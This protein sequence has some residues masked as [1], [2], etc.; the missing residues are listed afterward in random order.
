MLASTLDNLIMA[1]QTDVAE[2][3]RVGGVHSTTIGRYLA[4]ENEPKLSILR[5][6]VRALKSPVARA[7]IANMICEGSDC[8]V[9]AGPGAGSMD[10]NGDGKVDML[11]AMGATS[12]AIRG[13]SS[14]LASLTSHIQSG[15]TPAT[16]R[17]QF[18]AAAT[19]AITAIHTAQRVVDAAP[20]IGVVGERRHARPATA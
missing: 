17:G 8:L 18:T 14:E 12:D 1:G 10:H 11:D 20:V 4:D 2:L 16:Y 15:G 19:A 5:A 9:V 7:A 13:L 3:A 6:W